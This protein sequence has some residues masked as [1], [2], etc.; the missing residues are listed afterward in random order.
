[1]LIN[2]IGKSSVDGLTP[3]LFILFETNLPEPSTEKT[4]Q[5]MDL[6]MN[7]SLEQDQTRVLEEKQSHA[8][9][10][11]LEE[12]SPSLGSKFIHPSHTDL[13]DL[14]GDIE[15]ELE[16][17]FGDATIKLDE[18]LRLRNG[19]VIT[20]D[21]DAS[22]PVAIQANGRHIANGEVLILNDQFCIRVIELV[23]SSC[24]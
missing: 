12:I 18:F 13:N 5:E 16:I 24:P 10:M 8:T 14:M 22:E 21:Q 19:A 1:M 9:P 11:H 23:G 2:R 7:R 15:I 20:L 17:T 6:D 4:P 3:H